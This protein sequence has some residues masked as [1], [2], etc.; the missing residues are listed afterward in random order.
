[1]S[2]I[3]PGPDIDAHTYVIYKR[4]Q[5]SAKAPQQA[6]EADIIKKDALLFVSVRFHSVHGIFIRFFDSFFN[7][8]SFPKLRVPILLWRKILIRKEQIREGGGSGVSALLTWL[9]AAGNMQMTTETA[10]V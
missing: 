2:E 6:T 4:A 1:M 3:S 9:A 7:A 5:I 10:A 8:S